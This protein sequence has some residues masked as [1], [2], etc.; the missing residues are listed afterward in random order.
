[1]KNNKVVSYGAS[2]VKPSECLMMFRQ[3]EF[4]NQTKESV[5]SPTPTLTKDQAV[6]KAEA[7]TGG[8]YNN[9]PTT[10]EV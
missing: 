2:F 3:N 5:S 4:M 9:W 7:A 6:A 1:M 10:L 8:K